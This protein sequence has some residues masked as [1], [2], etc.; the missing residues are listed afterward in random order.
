MFGKKRQIYYDPSEQEPVIQK[1]ICTGETTV[2]FIDIA[3]GKYHDYSKVLSE[4]DI[5][6]FCRDTGIDRG[7][8]RTV[9]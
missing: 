7:D 9:Y 6:A 3:T 2:G 8:I 4:D 1:S 5:A